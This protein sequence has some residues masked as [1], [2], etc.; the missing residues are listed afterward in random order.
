MPKLK[1]AR[2]EAYCNEYIVDL[3]Q[4]QAAIRAGYAET[5]ARQQAS[6]LMTKDNIMAR[7]AE[8]QAIAC[9]KASVTAESVLQSILDIRDSA[10]SK[11]AIVSKITGEELGETMVDISGGLKANELLGKHLKLFTDKIE[12]EVTK[13][14]TIKIVK[15]DE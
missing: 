13:M 1:D 2:Q 10:T 6:K 15:G 14:P 11:I 8:L 4:T 3:I 7:I 12:L 9:S 5:S